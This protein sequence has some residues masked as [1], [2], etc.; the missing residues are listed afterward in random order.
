MKRALILVFVAF[1]MA[2]SSSFAQSG[3]YDDD[4]YVTKRE[5]RK[6]AKAE[7]AR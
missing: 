1:L 7:K 2:E 5:A 6:K 3:N 4:I